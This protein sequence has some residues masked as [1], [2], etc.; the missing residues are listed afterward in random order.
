MLSRLPSDVWHYVRDAPGTYLWL[1]ALLAASRWLARL[2]AER[3]S[4][5]LVANSTN[6]TGLRRAPLTV[7]VTSAFFTPGTSWLFCLVT[8]S[9][10]HAPA[11]H[12]LGTWR[13]LAVVALAH[14]GATLISQGCVAGGIRAGRRPESEREAP[15][16]GVSYA[17]AG[18]AAVLAYRIPVP[19]RILYLVVLVGFHVH[20]LARNRRDFTALGHVCAVAIGLGCFWIVP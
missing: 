20:G 5:V 19:W 3:A 10:F 12:R 18:V 2:P 8:Y 15:D 13:W 17:L 11:E 7:L 4:R 14:V 1:A 16:Y 6:L 9:V